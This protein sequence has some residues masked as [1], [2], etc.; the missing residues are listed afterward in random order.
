MQ[1]KLTPVICLMQAILNKISK[2]TKS[3][4]KYEEFQICLPSNEWHKDFYYKLQT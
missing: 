3:N 1:V 4:L 2:R